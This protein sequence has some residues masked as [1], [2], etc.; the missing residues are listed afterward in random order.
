MSKVND[1]NQFLNNFPGRSKFDPTVVAMTSDKKAATGNVPEGVQYIVNGTE[2]AV[3]GI[4]TSITGVGPQRCLV[5]SLTNFTVDALASGA[6]AVGAKLYTLP[7][8]A[9]VIKSAYVSVGL[10]GSEALNVADTPDVGVGTTIADG[11]VAVLGGTPAFENILTG[12]TAADVAGTATV[13][14]VS[15]DTAVV[16]EAA[17]GHVIFLNIADTWAGA[18][19]GIKATGTIIVEFTHMA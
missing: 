12:Q 16:I 4:K 2:P 19:T 13:K 17:S 11:A 9:C 8:G 18:D 7:A 15:K 6:D 5:I 3:S 10:E 14:T 1:R